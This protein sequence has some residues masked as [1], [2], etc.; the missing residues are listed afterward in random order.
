MIAGNSASH[1]ENVPYQCF[2]FQFADSV[3]V[4][5]IPRHIQ[6]DFVKFGTLFQGTLKTAAGRHKC[7]GT[8]PPLAKKLLS[9]FG[10]SKWKIPLVSV[11]RVF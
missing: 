4:A 5:S 10:D 11:A 1:F 2:F 7:D 9:V 8:L 6:T 3:R